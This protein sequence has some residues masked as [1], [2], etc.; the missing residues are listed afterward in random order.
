MRDG[1]LPL[2]LRISIPSI[3]DSNQEEVIELLKDIPLHL[4]VAPQPITPSATSLPSPAPLASLTPMPTATPTSVPTL[5]QLLMA[6]PINLL[7]VILTF[8]V[9]A[10]GVYVTYLTYKQ[11]KQGKT[12]PTTLD[13]TKQIQLHQILDDNY[14]E[15]E[16]RNLCI[17][18]GVDYDDLPAS[19]QSNKARELVALMVRNG[20]L[21]E[22]EA[23]IRND[24]P[25]LFPSVHNND[26][27]EDEDA[28]LT[29]ANDH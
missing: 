21:T 1:R 10:A 17:Q 22:L 9:G 29:D 28:N 6:E 2:S 19:G 27:S 24:R 3:I 15:E 13:T 7:G 8:I 11:S 5:T 26:K 20:R 25:Y 14:N 18:L 12:E 23:H 16:L 4:D